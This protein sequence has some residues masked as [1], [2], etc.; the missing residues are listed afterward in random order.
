MASPLERVLASL[1]DAKRSGHRYSAKCPVHQGTHKD[2]LSICDVEDGK[3]LLRCFGGCET[4]DVLRALGLEWKDLFPDHTSNGNSNG[5][6][7]PRRRRNKKAEE[8]AEADRI[9]LALA[10]DYIVALMSSPGPEGSPNESMGQYV[11]VA[12]DLWVLYMQNDS[13]EAVQT[14]WQAMREDLMRLAPK[15]LDAVERR[16]QGQPLAPHLKSGDST[17]WM[18]EL[19]TTKDGVPRET[20]GNITIA[21]QHLEPWASSCWYDEVR[22]IRMVG[23]HELNDIMVT[24]A[25]LAL[26]S[27]VKIPIRS[28]HLVPQALTYLCHQRP[29]DLLREWIQNLPQWD[30]TPRLST[31]L[32]TYAHAPNDAYSQDV[33][34]LLIEAPVVRALNPGCQYRGVPILEGPEDAGKTKLVRTLAT[35][36]WYRELSHGLDGKEAHM[37]IK[38]AWVAELAELSSFSK[39]EE[40]RLKSFFTLNE[41]AYIPKFSNFE[42]VHKRRTVFIGTVNPEGDNTYLRGQ[43]G[44]TRYLPV[45]VRDVNLEGFEQIRTQ[46]FAEAFQ[47]YR[48]HPDTWWQLSSDGAAVAAEVREERRQRSVYEDDLGDWLERTSRTVTW[49]EEIATEHLSLPKDRWNRN[50]QMAV[51]QALKALGWVKEKRERVYVGGESKLVV[52]WR[53]GSDWRTQP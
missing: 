14:S 25:A 40:A 5:Y 7:P 11:G 19:S 49:W 18:D 6:Y 3:V 41:D 38:R 53:P 31:W 1:P 39:T 37:R 26:E 36:E 4:A 46:L 24:E 27:Q 22:D 12:E 44:N 13:H 35:P 32:I 52:P 20:L 16:R 42:V 21:L 10:A 8:A 29:R 28:K 51:T 45:P 50:I 17:E 48:D 47:H 43:T 30:K 33:G 9:S 15:L 34:R 23:S 2:S